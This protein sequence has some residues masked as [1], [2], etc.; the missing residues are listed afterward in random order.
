MRLLLNK[1]H[2]GEIMNFTNQDR[3][4]FVTLS[5]CASLRVNSAKGLA[6]WAKRCFA[7]LILRCAQHDST[8][9]GRQAS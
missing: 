3:E 6:R 1:T 4:C 5:P 8:D 9:F 7:A 2:A